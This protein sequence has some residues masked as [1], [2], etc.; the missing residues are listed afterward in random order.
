MIS[1]NSVAGRKIVSIILA[2]V[3][4]SLLVLGSVSLLAVRASSQ[5]VP[6]N[7]VQIS[8][9]VQNS[10]DDSFSMNVFN[11]T[12]YQVASSQ[13]EYPG[14]AFE[15]PAGSYIFTATALDSGAQFYGDVEY[16]YQSQ[17]VSGPTSFTIST[18]S[19]SQ[20]SQ[21]KI[22]IQVNYANDSAASGAS[23]Y[24]SVL[25]LSYGFPTPNTGVWNETGSDGSATLTVPDV[26]VIVNAYSTLFVKLPTN[27]TTIQTTIAGE[28]VNVTV[29]WQPMYI[30][31]S[32][33]ALIVP[34][35]T[36]ATITL[37]Y[38]QYY[39]APIPVPVPVSV[40][41]ETA[42]PLGSPTPSTIVNQ[43]C[44]YATGSNGAS[45]VPPGTGGSG[46]QGTSELTT[47]A[48]PSLGG[49][50]L[51]PASSA[52]T[53]LVIT[54]VWVLVAVLAGASAISVAGLL[55]IVH[56]RRVLRSRSQI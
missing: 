25:G 50:S 56:S 18:E 28:Q 19:V 10:S 3:L 31:L 47:T 22:S 40:T 48:S 52:L 43:P 27:I 55:A 45:S 49:S 7:N 30:S 35:E 38:N 24:A 39:C 11:T 34:P 8:L 33:S 14:F 44:I 20:I 23:V 6:L 54:N 1:E 17:Q 32:G 51:S 37:H 46:V 36:S 26:P 13:S 15:L 42:S 53:G 2:V 12:G 29:Y 9:Q 21:T 41:T 4:G 16:G 5:S